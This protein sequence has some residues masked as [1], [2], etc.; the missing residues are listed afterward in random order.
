M[1]DSDMGIKWK[2]PRKT[3]LIK[4]KKKPLWGKHFPKQKGQFT[5]IREV[6]NLIK[7]F[8]GSTTCKQFTGKK[9]TFLMLWNLYTL[10]SHRHIHRW[11]THT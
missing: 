8:L 3:I 7:I 2:K 10:Q 1:G 11:H 5:M 4:K 6:Y 9:K